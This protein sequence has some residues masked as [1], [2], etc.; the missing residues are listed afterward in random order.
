MHKA[1][2]KGKEVDDLDGGAE[3][4]RDHSSAETC[5]GVVFPCVP[6]P[7]RLQR[8][9]KRGDYVY[10]AQAINILCCNRVITSIELAIQLLRGALVA[11]SLSAQARASICQGVLANEKCIRARASLIE[12]ALVGCLAGD[13][14]VL[15]WIVP[16]RSGR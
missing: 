11:E 10:F 1:V 7:E 5:V 13:R 6:A 16:S 12:H 4:F 3:L 9:S 2:G 8:F 15:V 14:I